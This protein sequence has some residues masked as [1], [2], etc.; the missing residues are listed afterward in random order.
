MRSDEE[1]QMDA[2]NIA[3]SLMREVRI[4]RREEKREKEKE[5]K[6]ITMSNLRNMLKAA[7][8]CSRKKNWDLFAL[9]VIYVAREAS[10][11]DDLFKFVKE[12]LEKLNE[13]Q[14]VEERLTLAKYI[15]TSCIYLYNAYREGLEYLV[16]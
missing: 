1:L 7:E 11:N 12:L 6:E 14:S 10:P 8:D 2:V 5:G 16:R 15:L 3:K 9:K 4:P 13:V